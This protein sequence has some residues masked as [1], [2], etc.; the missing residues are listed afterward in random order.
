MKAHLVPHL[1]LRALLARQ[2]PLALCEL[3]AQWIPLANSEVRAKNCQAQVAPGGWQ[4]PSTE[5]PR[6]E[7]QNGRH[8]LGG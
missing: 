1:A 7:N 5:A 2:E 4:R 8:Q 3:L 6:S